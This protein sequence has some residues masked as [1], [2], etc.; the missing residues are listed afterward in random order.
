MYETP[1]WSAWSA[2]N[3]R[4]RSEQDALGLGQNRTGQRFPRQRSSV[5]SFA[6]ASFRRF[7]ISPRVPAQIRPALG[8]AR[9]AAVDHDVLAID[10]TRT[11][12]GCKSVIRTRLFRFVS[13]STNPR[14]HFSN[15][16]DQHSGKGNIP[17][18]QGSPIGEVAWRQFGLPQQ[19]G[20]HRHQQ[21]TGEGSGFLVSG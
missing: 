3:K 1:F 20:F 21:I 16:E 8:H 4:Q 6:A 12:A 2:P 19:R 17:A 18:L 13:G 5:S 7:N 14:A 11:I 9:M 10:E 15:Q